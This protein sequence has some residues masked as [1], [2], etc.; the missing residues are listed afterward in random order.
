MYI[1]VLHLTVFGKIRRN[2]LALQ[3]VNTA[4]KIQQNA[5]VH[6]ETT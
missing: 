1:M 5:H 6:A 3:G 2:W 4:A